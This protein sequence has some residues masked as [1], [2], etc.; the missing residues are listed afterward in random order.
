MRP[1]IT[2]SGALQLATLKRGE[3]PKTSITWK[4]LAPWL[5]LLINALDPMQ[6]V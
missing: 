4:S 2:Q 3:I 5:E 1:A 6:T